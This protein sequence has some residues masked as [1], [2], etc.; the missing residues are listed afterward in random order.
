M[1]N[2]SNVSAS[3]GLIPHQIIST[4][5]SVSMKD[6]FDMV[7][8]A[9]CIYLVLIFIKQTKS[10]FILIA[11]VVLF[12]INFISQEFDL[13][14]T[15]RIFEPLL[16]FFIAIFI[17]VFQPE[18]RKFF[19][20]I[21]AGRKTTFAKALSL[22]EENAETIVRSV[23]EMAKKR[24]GAIIVLP[25]QYPLDDLIEGGFPLDGKISMPLI[26]SIFDSSSPGHDGAVLI[27]GSRIK[28]FGLHLPLA[29]EFSEYSRVGTRHRATAGITEKTDALAIAVSEER[30]EVSISQG[31]KLTKVN[32]PEE[33]ATVIQKFMDTESD[34]SDSTKSLSHYFLV[35]NSYTKI[36]AILLS[37]IFWFFLIHAAG[38]VKSTYTIPVE[39]K[40]LKDDKTISADSKSTIKV[41]VTGNNKDI[42]G[43][44]PEDIH[45]VIDASNFKIGENDLEI[46]QSNI[47]LPSYIELDSFTPKTL[48]ISTKAIVN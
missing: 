44:K 41:T 20:W 25:G 12:S 39:F 18:I 43:L 31:G 4:F 40:Y 3:V 42:A 37:I 10:T 33:L 34:A 11:T 9:I 23:F 14:L 47:K 21:S 19:K 29:R 38:I 22:P 17:I 27:E 35:K 46:N 2:L 36:A 13:A 15:R 45:A 8:V 26:L 24:V 1:T 28:M 48:E 7:I 5:L 6:V 32:T 30:G 16:T